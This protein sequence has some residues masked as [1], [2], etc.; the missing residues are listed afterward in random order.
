[1]PGSAERIS[2]VAP[3]I[4]RIVVQLPI[5]EVGS[6]NSYVIVD[7]DRNLII[8]PGMAHPDCYEIME[9]A[10]VDLG[11]DLERTDFFITH[12]HLDHFSAVSRFLREASHIYISR[13]EAEFIERIAAEEV[14]GEMRIFLEMLGF[15]DRNPG[16]LVSQFY[17]NAYRQRHSWPF[18]YVDDGDAIVRGNYH[19]TCLITPGHT[20]GHSCLYEPARSVLISGDQITAGIQFL[21]DRTNALAD[22][23][24]SLARLREMDVKLALPGHGSPFRNHRKRIDQLLAHHQGRSEAACGALGKSG[25]DAYEVTLAL[26][27]LLPDRDAL[28]TLPLIR[29]FIHTRHSFAYLQ[30]LAAEGKVRKEHRHGR[31]LFFPCQPTET[32][33]DPPQQQKL[34]E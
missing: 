6:V 1:M 34:H 12:H 30:H 15:P 29:K 32:C 25:K 16:N 27:G 14:E 21:L 20:I 33:P 8:D 2:E 18:L 11:L 4:F 9:K 26:D 31:I 5:P 19:F 7:G 17:S 10:V 28:D 24:Q 22:H 3:G 13:P 23:L